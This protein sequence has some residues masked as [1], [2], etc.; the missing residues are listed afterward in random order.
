[1][2]L[3]RIVEPLPVAKSSCCVGRRNTAKLFEPTGVRS[4]HSNCLCRLDL[5]DQA[6]AQMVWRDGRVRFARTDASDAYVEGTGPGH[7]PSVNDGRGGRLVDVHG[8]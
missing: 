2:N 5:H 1:A 4:S 6:I 3:F 7:L 8:A